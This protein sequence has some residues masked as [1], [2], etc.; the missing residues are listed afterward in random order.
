M[1][2]VFNGKIL[3]IA[4]IQISKVLSSLNRLIKHKFNGAEAKKTSKNNPPFL[5]WMS[6]FLKRLTHRVSVGGK[7]RGFNHPADSTQSC[8]QPRAF[9]PLSPIL[10]YLIIRAN[11]SILVFRLYPQVMKAK[12]DISA[13]P[14]ECRFQVI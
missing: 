4:F 13:L 12:Q 7:T 14:Q 10:M 6:F 2:L 9:L 3:T 8:S 11:S 5:L 1:A